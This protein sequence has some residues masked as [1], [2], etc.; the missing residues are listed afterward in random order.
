ML[1]V[2]E[3]EDRGQ[4]DSLS[5]WS[6][7]AGVG[8]GTPGSKW[9]SQTNF[10]S[11]L[12]VY[13]TRGQL[14]TRDAEC[15]SGQDRPHFLSSHPASWVYRENRNGGRPELF[16]SV[17]TLETGVGEKKCCFLGTF[18]LSSTIKLVR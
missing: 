9:H 14:V 15:V 12:V 3:E 11:G 1:A 17:K 7:E 16:Q 6:E 8:S 18:Q 5:L 13:P 4:Q 10:G 2:L